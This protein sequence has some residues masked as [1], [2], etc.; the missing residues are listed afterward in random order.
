MGEALIGYVP[1]DPTERRYFVNATG[2]SIAEAGVNLSCID[3]SDKV[4]N[5]LEFRRV[6]LRPIPEVE[7]HE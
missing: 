6:E 1:Y 5:R 4:V 7:A 3:L 2:S